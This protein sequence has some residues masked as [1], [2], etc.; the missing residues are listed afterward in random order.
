[1]SHVIYIVYPSFAIGVEQGPLIVIL[2]RIL[3]YMVIWFLNGK[4]NIFFYNLLL[5]SMIVLYAFFSYISPMALL[6]PINKPRTFIHLK[7]MTLY[8]NHQ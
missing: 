3:N 2:L 1:M 8:N 7:I 4:T 6:S 5:K